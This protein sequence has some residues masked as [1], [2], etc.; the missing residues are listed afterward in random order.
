[1]QQDQ[2]WTYLGRF[3]VIF[4]RIA[5]SP[6]DPNDRHQSAWLGGEGGGEET[7]L[8]GDGRPVIAIHGA[9]GWVVDCLGLVQLDVSRDP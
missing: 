9:R 3:K 8:G 4:M 7:L 1:V 6:L 5:G 2:K